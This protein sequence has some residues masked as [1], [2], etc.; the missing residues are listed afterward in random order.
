[1]IAFHAVSPTLKS[2]FELTLTLKDQQL[3]KCEDEVRQDDCNWQFK[4]VTENFV[5]LGVSWCLPWDLYTCVPSV[6]VLQS[7][8][9]SWLQRRWCLAVCWWKEEREKVWEKR[10]V[11]SLDLHT[12]ISVISESFG[13]EFQVATA[14]HRQ[15]RF[16][17][18]VVVVDT[19]S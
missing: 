9:K 1:M 14:E 13:S 2:T 3:W 15:A 16:A 7:A 18:V 19:V 10:N 6:N 4:R 17:K 11:F 8:I 12:V 5:Y